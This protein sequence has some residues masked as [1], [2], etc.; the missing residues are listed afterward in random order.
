MNS[1]EGAQHKGSTP[2]VLAVEEGE[3]LLLGQRRAPF[4]IKAS[5]ATGSHHL[6]AAMERIRPGDAIPVHRHQDADELIFL[7]S[8]SGSIVLGD[9]EVPLEAGSLAFV[10][11]G[12][13]HGPRNTHP[14][15]E[16]HIL[17]VFSKPGIDGYFRSIGSKPG[18]DPPSLPPSE[19]AD[20]EKRY[21][22]TYR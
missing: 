16:L 21:G 9:T 1:S 18:E 17:A 14:S 7:H 19:E 22:I 11:R 4:W 8:G 5:T 3:H 15:T 20:L 12:T 10:P 2:Y 13:W 6:T